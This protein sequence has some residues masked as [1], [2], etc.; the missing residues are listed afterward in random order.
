MEIHTTPRTIAG[1]YATLARANAQ[2]HNNTGQTM[3]AALA[4]TL[5]TMVLSDASALTATGLVA[6]RCQL[7]KGTIA[8]IS[9]VAAAYELRFRASLPETMEESV[10]CDHA[11]AF[12]ARLQ[13]A[14]EYQRLAEQRRQCV[15]AGR[16]DRER[17][18][19]AK[20]QAHALPVAALLAERD[21]LK[22]IRTLTAMNA[23]N[24]VRRVYQAASLA[25]VTS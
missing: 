3:R 2:R 5:A 1:L 14:K 9:R 25:R 4:A 6:E 20:A 10:V 19:R 22:A 24:C 11:L 15:I 17:L 23:H 16:L 21:A 18:L 13:V 7:T 12:A 8:K